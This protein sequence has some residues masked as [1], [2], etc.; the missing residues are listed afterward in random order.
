MVIL[1]GCST[2]TIIPLGE[3]MVALCQNFRNETNIE[4]KERLAYS[5]VQSEKEFIHKN[6]RFR[7]EIS[8]FSKLLGGTT[9]VERTIVYNLYMFDNCVATL[10]ISAYSTDGAVE[11]VGVFISGRNGI[12]DSNFSEKVY[13]SGARSDFLARYPFFNQSKCLYYKTEEFINYKGML[14]TSTIT[15][16]KQCLIPNFLQTYPEVKMGSIKEEPEQNPFICFPI[17]LE[18]LHGQKWYDCHSI[19][20]EHVSPAFSGVALYCPEKD[21][22]YICDTVFYEGIP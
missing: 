3:D 7:H 8:Q 17:Q 10:E 1:N 19:V 13:W 20:Q 9:E 5:I 2:Y 6:N 21:V 4:E 12:L 18:A 14:A 15:D 11:T 16:K 22:L